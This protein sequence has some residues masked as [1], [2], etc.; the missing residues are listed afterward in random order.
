MNKKRIILFTASVLLLIGCKKVTVD[1]TYSPAEPKAGET[2]S[3]TNLSSAGETWA[4]S[5]G[6]HSTS[7]SKNPSK[8]YKKAGTYTITLMVDSAKNQTYSKVITVRDTVPT[9]N[10]SVDSIMH[11]QDATFSAAIYNPYNYELTYEWTLPEENCIIYS[12][13]TNASTLTVYF[14]APGKYDIKLTIKQRDN[15]YTI[16][17]KYT[18]YETKAPALVVRDQAGNIYRQRMIKQNDKSKEYRLEELKESSFQADK[19]LINATCDT[20]VVF[21]GK[22][23][24][25]S[26]MQDILPGYE[27]KRMQMDKQKQKW[28]FTTSEGLFVANIQGGNVRNITADAIGALYID[29]N[30]GCLF[31]AAKDGL[32]TMELIN[33]RDNNFVPSFVR[34]NHLDNIDLITINNTSL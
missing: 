11:Y 25:A 32:Y 14:T 9:F 5:F 26:K 4:W 17:Q 1:F 22:T 3:F 27:V 23:F 31:W 21:N 7:L 15:T 28:Y 24:Y 12:G 2:V 29:A 16:E 20:I 8:I 6:D 19:D 13:N 34:Y 10:C 33:T 30:R 18:V